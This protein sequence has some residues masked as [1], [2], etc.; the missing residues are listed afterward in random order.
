MMLA[1]RFQATVDDVEEEHGADEEDDAIEGEIE[2]HV[3][4]VARFQMTSA[5]LAT[6]AEVT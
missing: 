5:T 4:V 1:V 2:W 3:E 6:E